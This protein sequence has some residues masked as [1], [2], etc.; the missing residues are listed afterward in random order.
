MV[1]IHH[2]HV[3]VDL[4]ASPEGAILQVSQIPGPD[5]PDEGEPVFSLRLSN[6]ALHDLKHE[7]DA[8][9]NDS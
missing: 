5:A 6:E 9:L 7:I 3:R 2:P 8:Y 4:L 1:E